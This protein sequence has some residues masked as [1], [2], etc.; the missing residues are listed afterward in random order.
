MRT[1]VSNCITYLHISTCNIH[2][3]RY[4]RPSV[5][6]TGS[7]SD[8]H[9]CSHFDPDDLWHNEGSGDSFIPEN[10]RVTF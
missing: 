2:L 9:L 4:V 5:P 7:F 3:F 6:Q 10:K 8:P 1:I